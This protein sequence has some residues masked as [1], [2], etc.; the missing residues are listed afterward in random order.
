MRIWPIALCLAACLGAN[1]HAQSAS[2]LL[3]DALHLTAV[4]ETAWRSYQ[5]AISDDPEASAQAR[6]TAM[7][8]PRLPTPRRLALIRA[9]M[10]A[11]IA[12]FDRRA[13]A[14]DAFYAALTLDQQAAFDRQTAASANAPAD[15]PPNGP[16]E[17]GRP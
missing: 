17:P 4:Q 2:S 10:Q 6:Q 1:A 8:L 7:L 9:Q 12:A 5:A 11:D 16:P 14:V 3:H 13:E 15:G